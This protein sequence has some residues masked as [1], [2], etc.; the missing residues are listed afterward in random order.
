MGQA[1]DESRRGWDCR[2][3]PPAP[4]PYTGPLGW[5]SWEC[6]ACGRQTDG[7]PITDGWPRAVPGEPGWAAP[8]LRATW[9]ELT[10]VVEQWYSGESDGDDAPPDDTLPLLRHEIDMLGAA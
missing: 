10:A 7:P 3:P 9:R 1:W 8:F 2:P 5:S 6:V 4:P